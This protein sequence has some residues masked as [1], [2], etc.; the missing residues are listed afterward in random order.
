MCVQSV[1]TED[2]FPRGSS[3]CLWYIAWSDVSSI[4]IENVVDVNVQINLTYEGDNTNLGS[5]KESNITE[6][7]S[8]TFR[9]RTEKEAFEIE[10][11]MRRSWNKYLDSIEETE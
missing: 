1:E 7:S 8:F 6:E 3:S 5:S 11:D 9:A 10:A 2:G 4:W